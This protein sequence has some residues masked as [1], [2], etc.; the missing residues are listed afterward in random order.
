[1]TDLF[2][3]AS[4]D[5]KFGYDANGN[6]VTTTA[7]KTEDAI[8]AS[9]P[10]PNLGPGKLSNPSIPAGFGTYDYGVVPQRVR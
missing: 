10:I 6:L 7:E 5:H 4:V 9:K 2:D 3:S 1:M 8:G